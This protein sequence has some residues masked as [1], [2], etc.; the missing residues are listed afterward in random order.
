LWDVR[1]VGDMKYMF[2]KSL[3][4]ESFKPVKGVRPYNFKVIKSDC[5]ICWESD[6]NCYVLPCFGTHVVCFGCI[7]MI[8]L[9]PFCRIH[10]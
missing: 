10:F 8:K 9:C 7:V 1:N 2:D 4:Q 5:V 3:I 6:V